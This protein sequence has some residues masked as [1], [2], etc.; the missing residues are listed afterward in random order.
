MYSA[1]E[2]VPSL[3]MSAWSNTAHSAG[4]KLCGE[5]VQIGY[6]F[7]VPLYCL[8]IAI[9][10]AMIDTISGLKKECL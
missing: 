1:M 8:L 2:M 9:F 6:S 10:F 7:D 3:V 5:I 4:I